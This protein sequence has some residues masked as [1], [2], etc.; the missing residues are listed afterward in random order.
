MDKILA[1]KNLRFLFF[2][3]FALLI[4]CYMLFRTYVSNVPAGLAWS[5]LLDKFVISLTTT[6]FLAIFLHFAT[7]KDSPQ[8]ETV[9]SLSANEINDFLINASKISNSWYFKGST[10]SFVRTSVMPT[11]AS[12]CATDRQKRYIEVLILNPDNTDICAAYARYKTDTS[13]TLNPTT[14]TTE[15]VR[16]QLLCTI[17]KSIYF[18]SIWLTIDVVLLNGFS[19]L[20]TDMSDGAAI[21][22]KEDKS[23]PAIRF[24]R[25]SPFYNFYQSDIALCEVQGRKLN[26]ASQILGSC[27]SP[28]EATA[29]FLNR[30]VALCDFKNPDTA[31]QAVLVKTLSLLKN[32]KKPYGK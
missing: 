12:R 21:L 20:R 19:V 28:E 23:A 22:T 16:A 29:E 4:T 27:P 10:A 14:W 17:Y 7:P 8:K 13:G 31:S 24:D 15:D 11:F 2:A 3:M 1:H 6:V 32:D 26:T 5:E 9:G 18:R 30:L 25:N